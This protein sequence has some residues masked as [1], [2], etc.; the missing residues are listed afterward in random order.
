MKVLPFL[1]SS[2]SKTEKY[3]VQF[4]GLNYGEGYADGELQDSRNLS[5]EKYPCITPR[6]ERVKEA[7]YAS[8]SSL[9]SKDGL[10]VVD[11]KSVYYNK[12]KVGTVTAGRKQIATIGNYIVIFPD[13][14]Y[15]NV[16]E[17]TFN[18]MEVGKQYTMLEFTSDTN[19]C[20][21]KTAEGWTWPFRVGDAV[22]ISRCEVNPSNNKTIIVRGVEGNVLKFY[23]NTLEA[24]VEP[25]GVVIRR[26]VPDLEYICESN[27]RLWGVS[28]NTILGSKYADPLNFFCYDGLSSDSYY[29]DV[30]TD[31]PFTGCIPYSGHICF[32]KENV[33]HKLYGAKP[34]NYQ[35][36]T[37]YV[38]GVQEGCERSL[39]LVNEQL[40]YKGVHGVYAYA[41]GVPEL[42]TAKFGQRRYSEAVAA[43]DGER[44]YISMKRDDA[45]HLFVFDVQ[46]G[47]WLEEDTI[48]ACDMVYHDG[49]VYML[50]D[51]GLWRVDREGGKDVEWSATFCPFNETMD[52]RKGYSRFNLRVEMADGA[53]LSV[54]VKTDLDSQWREVYTTHNERARIISVP[55]IPTRCDSVSIRVYGKGDVTIKALVR[56]FAVGSDV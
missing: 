45:W 10:L 15:Y 19:E 38:P 13:K 44:Y 7:Y 24:G 14:V 4:R 27:Y 43:C 6:R 54:A 3:M 22:E 49:D 52:E 30:G 40:L 16:A 50:C 5:S 53:W 42:L 29:V 26:N 17:G 32:F 41:G 2:K 47:I 51:D 8:P 21:I 11:G 25:E 35:L 31:G 12:V 34:S 1:K 55:I 36:L 46:H 39:A 20:T 48:H 56:E 18:E 37:S 23:A 33:L 28:G 9:H